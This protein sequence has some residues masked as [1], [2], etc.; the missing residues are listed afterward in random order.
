[1]SGLCLQEAEEGGHDGII[2]VV[3]PGS[4][5][6]VL[7]IRRWKKMRKIARI[8]FFEVEA[9]SDGILDSVAVDVENRDQTLGT[10]HCLVR[11]P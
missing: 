8:C 10:F 1:M 5:G 4:G 2:D 9:D 7:E 6:F 11:E 3:D